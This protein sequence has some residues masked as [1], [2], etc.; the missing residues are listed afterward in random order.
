MLLI[1]PEL[2][3]LRMESWLLINKARFLKPNYARHQL[4]HMRKC[5]NCYEALDGRRGDVVLQEYIFIGDDKWLMTG[6]ENMLP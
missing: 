5:S 1:C 4:S 6:N 2:G 3:F